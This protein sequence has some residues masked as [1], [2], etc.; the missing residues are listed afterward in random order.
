MKRVLYIVRRPL[1]ELAKETVDLILMSGVFEQYTTVFFTDGGVCQLARSGLEE[2]PVDSLPA[3][4]V[5]DLYVSS[6]HL[7]RCGMSPNDLRVEARAVRHADIRDL[8]LRHDVVI[9]D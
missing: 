6:E 1:G 2:S 4:G 5:H 8:I 9:T 3:Y 7:T